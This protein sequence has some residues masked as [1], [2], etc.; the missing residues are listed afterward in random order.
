M[1]SNHHRRRLPAA[2]V[3]AAAACYAPTAVDNNRPGISAESPVM[4]APP[5]LVVRFWMFWAGTLQL[6]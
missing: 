5:H 2:A 3:T 1:L 4:L 6:I